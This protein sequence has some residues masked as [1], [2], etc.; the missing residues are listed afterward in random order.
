L[1][2]IGGDLWIDTHP[3]LA[4]IDGLSG[5]TSIGGDCKVINNTLL[6]QIDGLQ[7]LSSI[8]GGLEI[9]KNSMLSEFCGLHTLLTAPANGVGSVTISG[10]S[11]NP[12][13]MDIV[14]GGACSRVLGGQGGGVTR[15]LPLLRGWRLVL[16]G[17]LII[18]MS[19]VGYCRWDC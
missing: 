4:N 14:D 11:S 16:L 6:T 8:S 15:P 1:Q 5:L 13:E 9:T 3:A 10:N 17:I 18:G 7:N 2:L 12:T 19:V